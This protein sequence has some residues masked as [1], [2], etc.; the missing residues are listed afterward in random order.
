MYYYGKKNRIFH[1]PAIYS[2]KKVVYSQLLYNNIII[3]FKLTFNLF[4]VIIDI[5]KYLHITRDI[6]EG[7]HYVILIF[8]LLSWRC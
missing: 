7:K 2:I 4:I 5:L 1:A 6:K 8:L 3:D